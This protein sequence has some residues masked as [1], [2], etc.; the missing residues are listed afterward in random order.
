MDWL[1]GYLFHSARGC[2]C[3][4][5]SRMPVSPRQKIS[6]KVVSKLHD[7]IPYKIKRNTKDS[8]TIGVTSVLTAYLGEEA[9]I[10]EL[11]SNGP[12]SMYVQVEALFQAFPENAETC[13]CI[14]TDSKC[15]SR[16][17]TPTGGALLTQT[18][19]PVTVIRWG[20]NGLHRP[21]CC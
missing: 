10:Q 17:R 12:G 21:L 20:F 7:S 15:A 8:P 14:L 11:Y 2:L 13:N 18:N 19:H 16:A 5:H 4:T 3:R 1:R 6:G 9:I